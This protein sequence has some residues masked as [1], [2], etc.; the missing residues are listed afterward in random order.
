MLL[1]LRQFS[2]LIL[3]LMARP[4]QADV[5]AYPPNRPAPLSV[6]RVER[7]YPLAMRYRTQILE[8]IATAPILLDT[9]REFQALTAPPQA[10]L[11]I[12]AQPTFPA[13][14]EPLYVLMSLQR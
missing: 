13:G 8:K 6:A 5:A 4:E 9:E 1:P 10:T 2:C 11:P 14:T 12:E 3:L 7:V